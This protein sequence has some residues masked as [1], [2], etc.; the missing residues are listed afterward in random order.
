MLL[1]YRAVVSLRRC[2]ATHVTR[3]PLVDM[4]RPNSGMSEFREAFSKAQHIAIITGAGVS[5]ESGLPTFRGEHEKWRKWQSQDLASPEAFS[6]YPSRVWEFYHHRRELALS[7]K[8]NSAH[9][10]I[11]ECEARL[12]KQ[13]RSVVVITQCIDD[14]HQQAGSK[15]VL[16][17]H[18]SL[19]ETRCLTCGDVTVNKRSPICASLKNKGSPDP[20]V[21]DADIPVDKLPR[22]SESDCHGLLRPNVVFFGETLNSHILT[23]VEKELE[24]CDL[25]LVVGTSSIVY[26]AAMFGP[27]V[28]SRGVPV[29]EF[30]LRMTPKSEYFTYHFHGPC[31]TTV[32]AALARHESE[33]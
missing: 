31:G 9:V 16:R 17:I 2:M 7:K 19:T 21:A 5:A 33:V 11:A 4:A 32:P 25:C 24:V 27:Q 20:N 18:G 14:L 12:K 6:R 28:A 30:N 22:C 26:P 13:G 8:P 1:Q 3:G 15:H 29:A 23:K 10:A